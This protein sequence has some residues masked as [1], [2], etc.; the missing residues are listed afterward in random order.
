MDARN[1]SKKAAGILKY[2][3]DRFWSCDTADMMFSDLAADRL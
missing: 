3:E 1:S 2:F